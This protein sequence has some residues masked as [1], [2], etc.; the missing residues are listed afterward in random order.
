MRWNRDAGWGAVMGLFVGIGLTIAFTL[1]TFAA[2]A[3][4]AEVS[5]LLV[6]IAMM[7]LGV[8]MAGSYGLALILPAP[9]PLL[10]IPRVRSREPVLPSRPLALASRYRRRAGFNAFTLFTFA[11]LFVAVGWSTDGI[12][13]LF[14]TALSAFFV[15][16]GLVAVRAGW[17]RGISIERAAWA[18]AS[19]DA[20]PALRLVDVGNFTVRYVDPWSGLDESMLLGAGTPR[21]WFVD[22]HVVLMVAGRARFLVRVD[23]GPFE[24]TP[25][26]SLAL[27]SEPSHD[28]P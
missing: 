19:I 3:E 23:G 26:E 10:P 1:L 27:A 2:C 15:V 5:E 17:R 8:V 24:L 20:A 25:A 18:R 4:G 9:R 7:L 11:F 6:G 22:G 28:R 14:F 16:L 12:A 21:P 13:W